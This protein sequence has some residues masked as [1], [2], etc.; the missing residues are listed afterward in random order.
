[1]NLEIN[2]VRSQSIYSKAFTILSRKRAFVSNDSEAMAQIES[3]FA[4][5][6]D[7]F[8]AALTNKALVSQLSNLNGLTIDEFYSLKFMLAASGLDVLVWNVAELEVN[9]SEIPEGFM[10]YNSV[11]YLN[12]ADSSFISFCTKIVLSASGGDM[13]EL[14]SKIFN[15][16]GLFKG[17][18]FV[19]YKNPV[20]NQLEIL[21]QTEE[22]MGVSPVA[23]TNYL[24]SILEYLKKD[25]IALMN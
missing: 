14:Y 8:D 16:Y 2:L 18:L 5:N 1:M 23:I 15:M 10:E 11:D 25:T 3:F 4:E 17:D 7:T 21:K 9:S 19:G 20:E 12:S 22:A 13:Y 6:L 24:N